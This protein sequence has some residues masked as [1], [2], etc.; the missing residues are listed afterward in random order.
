MNDSGNVNIKRAGADD[1]DAIAPLFDAYRRFYGQAADI[2][3][4]R[5]FLQGRLRRNE[6]VILL[7]STTF[8]PSNEAGDRNAA[9]GFVQ[10]Y[11][12]FSSVALKPL[13]LLNDLFVSPDHRKRGV[14]RALMQHAA[15]FA[16]SSGAKG[17]MLETAVDNTPAKAL[18]ESLDWK[19]DEAFDHY[20][21]TF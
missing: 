10:L 20:T 1:L 12:L 2:A 8:N 7:A 15:D 16:R 18:Y 19:R 3:R 17:L 14:A 4:A 5:T 9:A 6:S 11:P 13:W 21:L